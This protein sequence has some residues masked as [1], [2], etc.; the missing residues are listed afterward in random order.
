M[1]LEEGGGKEEEEEKGGVWRK[2][3][4]RKREGEE[5]I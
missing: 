5:E 1:M 2:A 4:W 3:K